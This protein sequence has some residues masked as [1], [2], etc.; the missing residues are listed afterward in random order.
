[1]IN[2]LVVDLAEQTRA[3]IAA[4]HPETLDD[5]RAC[6]PLAAFSPGVREQSLELKRFLFRNLY[7][8][9]RVVRMSEKAQRLIRELFGAFVQEPKLLPPEFQG[10]AESDLPRAVC[11]YIAGMTDRYA[12][13]EH[14]RIFDIEELA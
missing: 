4:H 11:D 1:M 5:I 3:N 9:Y 12:I 2:T 6:P 8:H 10:R 13:L 14:H 7:R